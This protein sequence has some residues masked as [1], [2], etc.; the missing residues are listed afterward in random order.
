MRDVH[1]EKLRLKFLGC[2]VGTAIGDALGARREGRR[3]SRS[4]DIMSLAE[5]L[6]Q[7]IYT[8]DTHM[9]I[10][11]AE[12]LIERKGFDGEHMAR[13]FIKN[14]E[15]EPW[16]GYGP[17]PPRIFRMIKDGEAWYSAAN[18]LYRGGSFGNG[19]AMRVA[20]VGLLYSRNPEKLREIAYQSSS[21]THSHELAREGAALQACAVAL[22]LNTPSDEGIDKEAFLSKLHD[23]IQNQLY[24]EKLAQIRKLLG[25]QD[26]AK[27]IAVLGNGIEAPRS[28][29]TAIYCF[30][31]QP[32][33]YEDTVTYAISLGGDADTIAAMAG[34]ISGAYLGID[35][36]PSE[37][38]AKLENREYIEALAE[39]LWQ[40]DVYSGECLE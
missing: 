18:R 36:T 8:D 38:R 6:E 3:M 26:K 2:L 12:S 9:T 4:E 5:K 40:L 39:N 30:L 37:W 13:T 15:A 35:A 33:S 11:I 29:P 32:Q 22:A 17:G 24:R 7:L 21:I 20:P 14:Y 27:V 25:E 34:A 31:R 1:K 10:G 23:F 19:S 16:R 28:V